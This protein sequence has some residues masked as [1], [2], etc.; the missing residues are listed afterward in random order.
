[1]SMVNLVTDYLLLFWSTYIMMLLKYNFSG[2]H[3]Y[4]LSE[5]L[6][7]CRAMQ[8]RFLKVETLLNNAFNSIERVKHFEQNSEKLL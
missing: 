5:T 7:A 3:F 8:L 6:I 2:V 4:T 1:M